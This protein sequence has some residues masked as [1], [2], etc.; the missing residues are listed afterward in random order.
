[1]IASVSA[2]PSRL[3]AAGASNIACMPIYQKGRKPSPRS[4]GTANAKLALSEP[5]NDDP[6][7]NLSVFPC[8]QK[9][10]NW[11]SLYFG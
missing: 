3:P 2:P 9:C 10:I 11:V 1:M 6:I 5:K 4:L 7:G 8:F